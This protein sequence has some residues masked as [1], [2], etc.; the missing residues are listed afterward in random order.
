MKKYKCHQPYC[1][2][3]EVIVKAENEDEAEEIAIKEIELAKYNKQLKHNLQ[4]N[5][6]MEIEEIEE[7]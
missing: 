1:S 6:C 5:G 4:E 7:Q 2:F 3:I